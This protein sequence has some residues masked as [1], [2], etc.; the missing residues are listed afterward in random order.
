MGAVHLVPGGLDAGQA[1]VRVERRVAL[2]GEVFRAGGDATARHAADP[3]HAIAAHDLGI[4]P[5]RADADVGA[6]ALGQYVQHGAETQIDAQPPQLTRFDQALAMRERL[7]AGG[8]DG[9][10]VGEDRHAASQHH[11]AATLV[12]RR[13]QEPPPERRLEP[14]EQ[15]RELRGRLEIAPIE[16]EAGGARVA[17]ESH[18]LIT[19]RRARKSDHQSFADEV[20][21]VAHIAI[22]RGPG[23]PARRVKRATLC[24]GRDTET[25]TDASPVP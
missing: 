10:V 11:D 12:I 9:E 24:R 5:V 20:F 13:D 16:D 15:R 8:A 3:G 25:C 4:L 18:V 1:Q 19:E 6:V 17:K 7:F 2:A 21:E 22:L 23:P 14:S